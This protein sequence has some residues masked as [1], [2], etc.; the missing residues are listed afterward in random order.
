MK[1]LKNICRVNDWCLASWEEV[2]LNDKNTMF[3]SRKFEELE[4][5]AKCQQVLK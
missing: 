5:T 4:G 2:T 3:Q 1:C